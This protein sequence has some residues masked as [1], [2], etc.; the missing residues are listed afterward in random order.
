MA[1]VIV[2]F[3]KSIKLKRNPWAYLQISTKLLTTAPN[4]FN[5]YQ[6]SSRTY[7]KWARMSNQLN[8]SPAFLCHHSANNIFFR[9]QTIRLYS[10]SNKTDDDKETDSLKN[11]ARLP[12]LMDTPFIVWPSLILTI[13]NWI[14]VTFI[15]KPY[16]DN[17]FCL[18]DFG[19]GSKQ[20]LEVVSNRLASGDFNGLNGLVTSETLS[21]IRGNIER[22]SMAQRNAIAVNQEDVYF[23][24]PYQVGVIFGDDDEE[25][26]TDEIQK[27][28]VEITMIFHTL[29]DL[30]VLREQRDDLPLNIGFVFMYFSQQMQCVS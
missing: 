22:M 30:A 21:I 10:E 5:S 29:K 7:S 26:E 17:D 18:K 25:E 4:T 13:K 28:F 11:Q 20:A 14:F 9:Q 16:L 12:E 23:S 1:S 27:R 2:Q 3:S 8:I 6:S 19:R 24:F 15:I